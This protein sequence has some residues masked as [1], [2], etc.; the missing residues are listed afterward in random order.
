MHISFSTK[1]SIHFRFMIAILSNMTLAIVQVIYANQAHS[2]SLLSDALHNLGDVLGLLIA[3][4]A[5]AFAASK[6]YS[7]RYTYGYKNSTLLAAFMNALLLLLSVLIILREIF[8]KLAQP[9]AMNEIQVL[10]IASLGVL[11]NGLTALLFMQEKDK[12]INIKAAFLHLMLDA[13]TSFGVVVSALIVYCGGYQWIDSIMALMIGGIILFSGWKLLRRS[14][15]L[16]LGAVPDH[17]ALDEVSQYLITLPGVSSMSQL[18]IWAIGTE[19]AALT[20]HLMMQN[21]SHTTMDH[22]AIQKNLA[23]RFNIQNVTLQINTPSEESYA[24]Q[25]LAN[26]SAE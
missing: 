18:H 14:L 1:P 24:P 5:Q 13:L 26:N 6:N 10:F 12:D 11:I 17:I 22:L 25:Y 20:A 9:D 16:L 19:E 7:L 2:V 23:Q 3:W 21:R 8:F 15:D 4:G